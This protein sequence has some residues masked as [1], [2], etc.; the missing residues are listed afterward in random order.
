MNLRKWQWYLLLF[1][2]GGEKGS[3]LHVSSKFH[4][5]AM[6]QRD[7]FLQAGNAGRDRSRAHHKP[8]LLLVALPTLAV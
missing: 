7:H 4:A 2:R 5:C 8:R 1:G 3:E 6:G